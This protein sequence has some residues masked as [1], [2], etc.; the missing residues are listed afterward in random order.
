LACRLCATP[1]ALVSLV[2]DD[3]QWFKA[4]VGCPP[5]QTDLNSSVCAHALAAPD[6]VL[7]SPDL[8]T[9]VRTLANPFVTGEPFIRFYAGAPLVS[10]DGQVL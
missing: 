4:R 1:V 8:T 5:C 6:E 9:D 7:V 2:A 10:P 3:R